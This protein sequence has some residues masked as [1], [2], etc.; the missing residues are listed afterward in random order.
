MKGGCDVDDDKKRQ[1]EIDRLRAIVEAQRELIWHYEDQ[2]D[3]SLFDDADMPE[4]L[5]A[6]EKAVEA[7]ER[8]N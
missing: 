7:A 5:V 3:R 8:T 2:A 1:K 6:L 4:E